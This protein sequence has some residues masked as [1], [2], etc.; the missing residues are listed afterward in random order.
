MARTFDGTDDKVTLS[1]GALGFTFGPGTV[2]AIV[3]WVTS[4]GTDT[5]FS[6]GTGSTGFA[7]GYNPG[8]TTLEAVV[9]AASTTSAT[10]LTSGSWYLV[11]MTKATGTVIPRIHRYD[12]AAN[13]HSHANCAGTLGD[14]TP[15]TQAQIG[16]R[17]SA[18]ALYWSGDIAVVGCWNVVLTDAQIEAM[19]FSLMAW[20]QVP[21]K[22]LW[23]LDQAATT[24]K[25]NDHSGGGANESALVGTAV[26]AS[27]VP[28][29]SYGHRI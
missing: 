8:A 13:S 9:D 19:A 14:T 29:F 16:E 27:S 10:A 2:A 4:A 11:A 15:A 7:L 26:A 18:S 17:F 1:L 20:H 3:R 28:V 5:I 12:Y 6:V 22:G 23:V 21:P 24:M 25:V